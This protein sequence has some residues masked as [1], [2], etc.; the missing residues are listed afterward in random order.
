M[1]ADDR[2]TCG[3]AMPV[4]R[5]GRMGIDQVAMTTHLCALLARA[6]LTANTVALLHAR[7]PST[8]LLRLLD[9]VGK[10]GWVQALPVLLQ[11]PENVLSLFHRHT[12]PLQFFRRQ[13]EHLIPVFANSGHTRRVGHQITAGPGNRF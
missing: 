8:D 10:F 12:G 4:S 1:Y 13:T 7:T 3:V 6:E 9:I 5:V 11:G 2:G